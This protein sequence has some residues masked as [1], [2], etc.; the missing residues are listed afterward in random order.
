MKKTGYIA[1]LIVFI[2]IIAILGIA[3][4]YAYI[5]VNTENKFGTKSINASVACVELEYTESG[6]IGL[7]GV[8][9]P[10]SDDEGAKTT[11]VVV[12]VKNTCSDTISYNLVISSLTKDDESYMPDEKVYIQV[13]KNNNPL[14]TTKGLNTLDTITTGNIYTYL[15]NDLQAREHVKDYKHRASYYVAQNAS[16]NTET[17]DTYNIRMWIHETNEEDNSTQGQDFAVALSTVVL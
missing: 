4:T 17:T 16:L 14:I 8:Q 6:T 13:T 2:S 15:T 9:Y 11:P 10:I 7:T 3:G 1:Y 12:T 5:N